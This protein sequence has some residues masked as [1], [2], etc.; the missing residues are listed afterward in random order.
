MWSWM[1]RATYRHRLSPEVVELISGFARIHAHDD[2][3]EY[4]EAWESWCK[5]NGEILQAECERLSEAGFEGDAMDKIFKAGRYYFRK[6]STARKAAPKQR[7][8]YAGTS[9]D[10][11]NAMDAFI[12]G[13]HDAPVPTSPAIAYNQFL[14]SKLGRSQMAH[15][16]QLLSAQMS[17]E[18]AKDKLKKTFKNRYYRK[19][20]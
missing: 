16:L 11:L 12:K 15:E 19:V 2:R 10:T 8:V 5:A 14:D 6:K 18:D 7:R 20:A 9:R 4:K 13:L 17:P 1:P 3:K